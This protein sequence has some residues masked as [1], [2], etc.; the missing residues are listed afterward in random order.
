MFNHVD[1][2]VEYLIQSLNNWLTFV[3]FGFSAVVQFRPKPVEILNFFY[4]VDS[5]FEVGVKLVVYLLIAGGHVCLDLL[6]F[7]LEK[8]NIE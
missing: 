5:F 3:R 7:L 4:E 1:Y 2:R 8:I 6:E